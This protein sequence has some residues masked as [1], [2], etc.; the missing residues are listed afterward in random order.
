MPHC[1]GQGFAAE[2]L[3]FSSS[4]AEGEY[5]A[6]A[7]KLKVPVQQLKNKN[8]A[9]KTIKFF[10]YQIQ[11]SHKNNKTLRKIAKPKPKPKPDQN[12]NQNNNPNNQKLQQAVSL[13][14]TN[15]N[16]I[17]ITELNKKKLRK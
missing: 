8:Q 12:Q 5:K 10:N 13:T 1:G 17:I 2:A 4:V 16:I 9:L 6:K 7:A 14:K 15:K 3:S 11:M